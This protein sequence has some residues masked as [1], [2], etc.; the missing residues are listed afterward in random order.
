MSE[1]KVGMVIPVYL[2]KFIGATIETLSI[3]TSKTEVVY[4]IVNDSAV[5]VKEYL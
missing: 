4:C 1:Y 2:T 5:D 3:N